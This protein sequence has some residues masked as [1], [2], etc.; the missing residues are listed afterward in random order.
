MDAGTQIRMACKFQNVSSELLNTLE[1]LKL[2]DEDT[3]ISRGD[4]I[5]SEEYL[6]RSDVIMGGG[7]SVLSIEHAEDDDAGQYKCL[8]KRGETEEQVTYNVVLRGRLDGCQK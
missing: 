2:G 1:W 7:E 8:L 6:G 5:V 3:V 4:L